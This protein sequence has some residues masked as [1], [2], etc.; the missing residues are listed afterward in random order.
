MLTTILIGVLVLIAFFYAA[1]PLLAPGQADPL[2]D[3]RDPVLVD[4]T[5]ERDALLRAIRELDA[6]ED[7]PLERR[8]QL[9]DRYEAKAARVLTAI[10]E[11]RG[12]LGGAIGGAGDRRAQR[13]AGRRVPVGAVAVL[14]ISLLLAAALPTYLL[15]R[16]SESDT[17]TTTDVDAARRLQ[18]VQR[19]ARDDPSAANLLALGDTYLGLQRVGEAEEAYRRILSEV[20]PVPAAAYKRLAILSLQSD[21]AA[22]QGWLEQAR[23]ADP[24]DP[25]TLYLLGEVAFARQDLATAEEAYAAFAA[26]AQGAADPA[27]E[28]RLALIRSLVPLSA[29]AQADPSLEN[30]MAVGD[31]YWEA[32]EPQ[33]A[34][35]SYFKVLTDHDPNQP[36]ALARTGQLLYVAG[37]PADAANAIERAAAAAGGLAGLDA[38]SVMTLADA[39]AQLGAWAEAA[40]TYDAYVAQV[41]PAAGAAAA[42]LADAARAQAAGTAGG[43]GDAQALPVVGRQVFTANCA[44]CH[45]LGGEGGMGVRLAGSS[46]AANEANVRDA[47]R[48]GRGMMPAFQARLEPR[49]LDAVVAYVTQVLSQGQAD[50]R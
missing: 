19:A 43:G 25:E 44:E 39:Y 13:G 9:H 17:I 34:V 32:G 28:P 40:A 10:D 6:R 36:R 2:P 3:D 16:V 22:A 50:R 26:T 38:D 7:L 41:G 12:A 45:G 4:L 18:E 31:A 37:R 48:F 29:A 27:T 42:A 11:R 5:E 46:R 14:A 35:A 20:V 33:P 24:A 23:A 8:R 30:L 21:L 1:L 15:P 49:D 47:V